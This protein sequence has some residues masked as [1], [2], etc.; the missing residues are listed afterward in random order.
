MS[1]MTELKLREQDE[2][3]K[4]ATQKYNQALANLREFATEN[5]E[6][7]A[8]LLH[9]ANALNDVAEETKATIQELPADSGWEY[10]GFTKKRG[11]VTVTYEASQLPKKMLDLPGVIK[12]VDTKMVEKH[13]AAT[14]LSAEDRAK[15][16]AAKTTKTAKASVAQPVETKGVVELLVALL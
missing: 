16:M 9:L 7:L 10:G 5:A 3:A 12:S 14:P 8:E 1:D 6:V 11:A 4:L 15:V 13:L 2:Q